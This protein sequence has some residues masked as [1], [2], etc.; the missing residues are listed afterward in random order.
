MAKYIVK[1]KGN[2]VNKKTFTSALD[3][4][5]FWEKYTGGAMHKE[6]KT[7]CDPVTIQSKLEEMQLIGKLEIVND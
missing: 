1:P 7:L 5:S 2:G 4:I 3:A 6:G